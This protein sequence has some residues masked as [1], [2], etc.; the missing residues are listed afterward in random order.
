MELDP[1][2]TRPRGQYIVRPSRP[3][4]LQGLIFPIDAGIGERDAVAD[5]RL[6]PEARVGAAGLEDQYPIA[7]AGGQPVGQYAARGTRA[8]DDVVEALHAAA[9]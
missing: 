9:A 2:T 8:D 5:R 3:G 1:P 6:D 4:L 7:P